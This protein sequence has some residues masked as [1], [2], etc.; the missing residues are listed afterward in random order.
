MIA[1]QSDDKT[2][3]DQEPHEGPFRRE[4]LEWYG[5]AYERA[6]VAKLEIDEKLKELAAKLQPK[7]AIIH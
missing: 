2:S 3:A 6:Y 1:K 5:E 4:E 7:V